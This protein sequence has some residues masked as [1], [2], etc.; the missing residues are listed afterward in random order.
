MI[1]QLHDF[2]QGNLERLVFFSA[3]NGRT[4]T[5]HKVFVP[6]ETYEYQDPVTIDYML[7]NIADV[8]EKVAYTSTLRKTLDD[9]R[10]PYEIKKCS[11]CSGSNSR[12]IFY[13]PFKVVE[14]KDNER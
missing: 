2:I 1:F 5:A 14:E 4:A 12:M 10:V 3:G 9:Y 8:R 7:N 13:N 11:S 6:G